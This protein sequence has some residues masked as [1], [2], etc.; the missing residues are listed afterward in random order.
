MKTLKVLLAAILI[1]AAGITA[2]AQAGTK[3]A[4]N[5]KSETFKV[6]GKCDMCKERIETAAKDAGAATA[7]WSDNSKLLTVTFDPA[8]SG[9]DGICKKLAAVGHDTE[10]YKASDEVYAKL[11]GCCHYD[12]AK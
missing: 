5:L 12:R 7:S 4:A 11:P 1:L 10:K 6:W 8:R 9:K 2:S 3:S